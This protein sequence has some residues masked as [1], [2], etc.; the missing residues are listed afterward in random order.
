MLKQI[1]LTKI[2][3]VGSKTARTLL[4]HFGSVNNIFDASKQ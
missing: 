1:A 4:A 3:G 2:K